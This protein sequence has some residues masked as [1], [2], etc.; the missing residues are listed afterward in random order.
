[1]IV[2]VVQAEEAVQSGLVAGKFQSAKRAVLVGDEKQ[3]NEGR[4][5]TIKL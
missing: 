4:F 1:L 3:R 5:V 2:A